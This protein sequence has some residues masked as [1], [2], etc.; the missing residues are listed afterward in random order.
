MQWCRE[1]A[2]SLG[3]RDDVRGACSGDNEEL[4]RGDGCSRMAQAGLK[5]EPAADGENL[6]WMMR[7]V[8]KK[9]EA[10]TCVLGAE[11]G[12]VREATFLNRKLVWSAEGTR[13]EPDPK[14]A[15]II[16]EETGTENSKDLKELASVIQDN[17]EIHEDEYMDDE[18]ANKLRAV[19]ARAN[20]LAR[21]RTDLQQACRCVCSHMAKPS[22][23]YYGM[24]KRIGRYF[25]RSSAMCPTIPI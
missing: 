25:S 4:S 14:H 2:T 6:W 22:K 7:E 18:A 3:A 5:H 19:A 12:M 8:D 15:S 9:F 20:F 23:G 17:G 16:M 11:N 13:C 24:M 21:D 10:K 1:F